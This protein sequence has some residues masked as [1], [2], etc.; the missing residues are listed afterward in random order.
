MFIQPSLTQNQVDV[1]IPVGEYISI[2]NTGNE[3]T[4]VLI[5][6]TN[7]GSQFWNYSEIATLTNTAQ[8]FGP[9]TQER[10][11][12]IQNRNTTVEYSIGNSPQ[13]R[14]FP[15]LILG[16]ITP[17]GLVEVANTFVDL[18]YGDNLGNAKIISSGAHGLTSSVAVG[19]SIYI[20]WSLGA[21]INGLYKVLSLDEDTIGT[22]ITIDLPYVGGL[23]DPIVAVA[24]TEVIL[25]S[26]NI[27]GWSMGV[28]GTTEIDA[29]FSFTSDATEKIIEMAYGG[30]TV[31]YAD[32]ANNSSA[33]VQKIMGNYGN[34]KIITNSPIALGPGLSE[35]ENLLFDVDATKDQI[36]S[37]IAKPSTANNVIRL[38]AFKL[39]IN[40]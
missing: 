5:K 6:D 39:N 19:A 21:G 15:S 26:V 17:I 13:L 25:K 29:I 9:Y 3:S 32:V 27:P 12:R 10:T 40:F 30:Q 14:S 23:G 33:F 34:S 1:I 7:P 31:L 35:K 28:G 37:I 11:I 22:A 8:M 20:A 16:S 38:D 18:A 2:G 4:T 24:N 36:F